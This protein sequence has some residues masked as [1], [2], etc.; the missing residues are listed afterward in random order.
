MEKCCLVIKFLN[1]QVLIPILYLAHMYPKLKAFP[2]LVGHYGGPW[3]LQ[4]MEFG[5]FPGPIVM[6][7]NCLIEPRKSY[8][9]RIYTRSIVGWPGVK[10][11]T[12]PDFKDVIKQ[13]SEMKGFERYVDLF[14]KIQS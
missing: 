12:T 14:W 2:H 10:H 4:K 9:D 3:Q 13:A 1:Y 11:L 6:T 8:K 7:S 5:A